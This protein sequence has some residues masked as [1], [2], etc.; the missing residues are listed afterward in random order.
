MAVSFIK[1]GAEAKKALAVEEQKQAEYA[2]ATY[3]FWL[4]KDTETQITFLDG[5]LDAD[6]VLDV[7][8]Y[9][10]HQVMRNGSWQ[11][12]YV[13]TQESPANPEPCPICEGGDKPYLVRLLTIIDHSEYD[14][15]KGNHV[16]NS[17]KLYA[18]KKETLKILQKYASSR[19]GLA[20]WRVKVSRTSDANSPNTG[21]VF[22][23]L[24]KYDLAGLK[25]HLKVDVVDYEK[26]IK[27]KTAK[28][29][30]ALGFG[31][32]GVV[33]QEEEVESSGSGFDDFVDQGPKTPAHKSE[34]DDL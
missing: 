4:P 25:A 24:K 8:V 14:T 10:E 28:E 12:W 7:P 17:L 30:R 23:F 22:D 3:R 34:F 1:K 5:T 19:G 32:G 33:G 29:L 26:E 13:C 15:K 18:F 2:N 31:V 6:G 21:N 9:Y 16:K 27:Y 20:G 11:N